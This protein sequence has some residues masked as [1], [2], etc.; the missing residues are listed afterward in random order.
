VGFTVT[1]TVTSVNQ[2]VYISLPQPG[3]VFTPSA[4]Q[5]NGTTL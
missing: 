2:P 5:L 4:S 1:Y 3:Q